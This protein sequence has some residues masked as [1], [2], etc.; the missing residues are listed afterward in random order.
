MADKLSRLLETEA[1]LDAMLEETRQEAARLVAAARAEA[2]KKVRRFEIE[3]SAA[4]RALRG[5]VELDR[6]EAIAAIQAEA[7]REIEKLDGLEERT[8]INLAHYV[9]TRLVGGMPGEPP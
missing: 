6:D 5:K 2:E 3:L 1:E 4:D 9:V 7:K 8:I